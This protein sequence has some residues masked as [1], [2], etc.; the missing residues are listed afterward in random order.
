MNRP[1]RAFDPSV[2]GSAD[3]SVDTLVVQALADVSRRPLEPRVLRDLLRS[4]ADRLSPQALYV[5]VNDYADRRLPAHRV[6]LEDLAEALALPVRLERD[7]PAVSPSLV[8]RR[9]G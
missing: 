4:V 2:A 5:L 8:L 6:F 7:I 3:Q 9:T 1:A